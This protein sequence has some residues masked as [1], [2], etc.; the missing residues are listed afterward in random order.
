MTGKQLIVVLYF[1]FVLLVATCVNC[2]VAKADV[3]S[4]N[5][6]LKR[7]PYQRDLLFPD[8]FDWGHEVTLNYR[9]SLPRARLWM[10]SDLTAQSREAR[11]R[12]LWWDYTLGLSLVDEVDLVWDHRSQH[13]I[14]YHYDKF[15]VRDSYGIRINFVK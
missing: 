15:P 10:E 2:T 8:H 6:E 1:F 12:N 14:D 7:M 9:V 11:F 13:R 5:L 4:L 3:E